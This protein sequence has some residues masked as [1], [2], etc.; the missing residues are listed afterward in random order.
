MSD[1]SGD[2][3]SQYEMVSEDESDDAVGDQY[4]MV[5]DEDNL[6]TVSDEENFESDKDSVSSTP[7][8]NLKSDDE[9]HSNSISNDKTSI[10]SEQH[11]NS[12]CSHE[13]TLSHR[14]NKRPRSEYEDDESR[15]PEAKRMFGGC[16]NNDGGDDDEN[17]DDSESNFSPPPLLDVAVSDSQSLD[18]YCL[19]PPVLNLAHEELNT[20]TLD[21]GDENS[22][23]PFISIANIRN[24]PP[25]DLDQ[26]SNISSPE[27]FRLSNVDNVS[28]E[29]IDD[30]KGSNSNGDGSVEGQSDLNT[31]KQ[32]RDSEGEL[33]NPQSNRDLHS[34]E[35]SPI[36]DLQVKDSVGFLSESS[37]SSSSLGEN[38]E[39]IIT[40]DVNTNIPSAAEEECASILDLMGTETIKS[41]TMLEPSQ[42]SDFKD[43]EEYSKQKPVSAKE[44]QFYDYDDHNVENDQAKDKT[45]ADK[46]LLGG[47]T[48]EKTSLNMDVVGEISPNMEVVGETSP[49]ME[50]VDTSLDMEVVD[51]SSLDMEVVDASSLDIEDDTDN[52]NN[53]DDYMSS[54]DDC[55]DNEDVE[56]ENESDTDEEKD[57]IDINA[58]GDDCNKESDNINT[59]INSS[60]DIET[61][62]DEV[63]D[64]EDEDTSNS[65]KNDKQLNG[66]EDDNAVGTDDDKNDTPLGIVIGA[67]QG[68]TQEEFDGIVI[69]S[70]HGVS[71]DDFDNQVDQSANT[72]NF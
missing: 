41:K 32:K 19:N 58:T 69:D 35:S 9:S 14:S 3:A 68:V 5:S 17:S 38:V 57:T 61:E 64:N 47:K 1:Y 26:Y 6:E 23:S 15:P 20:P 30:F 59:S 36:H 2:V 49:N 7:I 51:A 56:K 43:V 16:E 54:E 39:E 70:V 65:L 37:I 24:T 40:E 60:P 42:N 10:Q 50:V 55:S 28:S 71:Q 12:S 46:K 22:G 62:D 34:P 4:D 45:T 48:E 63:E 33:E 31:D 18:S 8:S 27:S 53:T 25:L 29:D 66:N 11:S 67:V 52:E 13:D 44:K 21:I 72:G